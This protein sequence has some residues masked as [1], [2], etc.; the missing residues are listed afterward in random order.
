MSRAPSPLPVPAAR[1]LAAGV[2]LCASLLPASSVLAEEAAGTLTAEEVIARHVEAR[3]GRAA[4]DAVKALELQGEYTAFSREHPF[5][6]RWADGGLYRFETT[7]QSYPAA[8]GVDADG[9][10][11]HRPMYD[12]Q[13]ARRPADRDGLY[14]ALE[15]LLEP[16]LFQVGDGGA[17]AELLGPG[18]VDGI[19]TVGLKVTFPSGLEETWHLDAETFL[20]VAV[21][22]TVFDYTQAYES[23]DQRAY[24]SDFREVEGLRIPFLVEKEYKSRNTALVVSRAVVNPELGED[25]FRMP[26]SPP[27]EA[28]RLLEGRWSVTVEHRQGPDQPWQRQEGLRAEFLPMVSGLAMVERLA[29]RGLGGEPMK[30]MRTY[31]F[32][33][34]G[35][36]YRLSQVDDA[37]GQM[38]VFQGAPTGDERIVVSNVDTGTRAKAG[39]DRELTERWTFHG[40]SPEGGLTGERG[41]SFRVEW[42]L[43]VDGG[44]SWFVA[45]KFEYRR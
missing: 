20:E 34:W 8:W 3:G 13:W 26:L 25:A 4:W 45:G 12:L 32:D 27:M 9:P 44:E 14:I 1:L 18:E 16:P 6:A 23:M 10:W 31:S 28:L 22:S 35:E 17:K 11:W 36:V 21:D 41:E 39:A 42:E 30:V 24:Y 37:S 5:T 7:I 29:G 2:L 33:R 40:L 43:S 15:G 19:D 38:R